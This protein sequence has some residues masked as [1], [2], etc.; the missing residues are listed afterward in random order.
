MPIVDGFP[1]IILLD[2]QQ[3]GINSPAFFYWLSL[4]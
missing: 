4:G 2:P 1:I 3:K